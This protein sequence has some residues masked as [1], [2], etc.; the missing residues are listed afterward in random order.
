MMKTIVDENLISFKV[1]EQKIFDYVCE[2]G[3][4]ITKQVLEN[5]DKELAQGRDKKTLSWE[6]KT[7]D[8]H[9]NG[10]WGSRI[11]SHCV[12]DKDRARRD[13]ICLSVG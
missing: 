13:G 11:Q 2:L 1:L 7:K 9:Q 8:Q 10:I 12:P 5:Y 3:R 6:R 4:L